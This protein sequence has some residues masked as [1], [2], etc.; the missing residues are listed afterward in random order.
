MTLEQEIK[1]KI[2]T[3]EC[4]SA[5][6]DNG[7][8]RYYRSNPKNNSPKMRKIRHEEFLSLVDNPNIHILQ[9]L[10]VS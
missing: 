3:V 4:I 6:C 8:W 9:P 10:Y 2:N 1:E 5:V 7:N